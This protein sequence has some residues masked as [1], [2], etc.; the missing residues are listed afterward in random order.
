M[1]RTKKI[2]LIL[3][4]LIVA[5]HAYAYIWSNH[6]DYFPELPEGLSRW[7]A[8]LTE[9]ADSDD[10]EQLTLYYLFG[11]SFAVASG[12][13]LMGSAILRIVKKSR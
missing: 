5:T 12:V 4:W 7:I 10:I 11:V 2:L 3:V 13:T 1:S 9:T 8:N 6:L